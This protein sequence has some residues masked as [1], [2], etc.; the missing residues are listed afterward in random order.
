MCTRR[1]TGSCRKR[2]TRSSMGMVVFEV[3]A[4]Q[5]LAALSPGVEPDEDSP[6]VVLRAFSDHEAITCE[7]AWP[8]RSGPRWPASGSSSSMASYNDASIRSKASGLFM[9]ISGA[10]LDA[11][12][13]RTEVRSRRRP[14][15]D[16]VPA[17]AHRPARLRVRS[18]T[19]VSV[20][21]YY[22]ILAII[23]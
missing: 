13:G 19:R 16:P 11:A 10:S 15:S 7:A 20:R 23:L 5:V 8:R 18:R 17:L 21:S 1:L 6:D 14:P 2:G 9:T 22:Y 4:L 12:R 3:L